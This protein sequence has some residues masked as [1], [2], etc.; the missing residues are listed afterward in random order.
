MQKSRG[1]DFSS[2]GIPGEALRDV[3]HTCRGLPLM[4]FSSSEEREIRT[5][6]WT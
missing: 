3:G 6:T 5:R 2:N 1:R 4:P